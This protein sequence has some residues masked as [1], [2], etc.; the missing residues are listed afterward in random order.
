M[1]NPVLTPQRWEHIRDE[2]QVGWA[3]PG[4]TTTAPPTA[5]PPAPPPPTPSAG[6]ASGGAAGI[7]AAFGQRTFRSIAPET[8]DGPRMTIGG[9]MTATGVLFVL[10][11]ATG[12]VG[13]TQVTE[14]EVASIDAQGQP[15]T[16]IVTDFPG[17]VWLPMIAAVILGFVTI[18]KPKLARITAPLYALGYGFAIGAISHMYDARFE[19]IVL[20]AIGAT[21]AVFFVMFL[22]YAT[23]II[24][25]TRRFVVGVIAA[26]AGIFVLYLTAAIASL[27]GA[28]IVFWNEPTP[29]GIGISVVI[30]IVAAL[31]LAID[32]SFIEEASKA[33]MPKYLEWFGA[34]GL[35]VTLI[36]LY[37]EILRLLSLL[38][39]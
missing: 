30:C 14:T 11:L 13:W 3:A 6:A 39:Q 17:W 16:T 35:T 8:T 10:L 34:F 28:D 21:L 15:T 25:V 19:G 26:T 22:L 33:G 9:T 18:F 38:R 32:F 1:P 31:N 37:L 23:R 27:F 5:P 20:Q 29:L 12:V 36:W 7:G 4:G 2:D 24:K